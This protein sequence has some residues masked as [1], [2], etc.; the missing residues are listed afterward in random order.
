VTIQWLHVSA[1]NVMLLC[2]FMLIA[3]RVA[4]RE[5]VAK[6]V[7][8]AI[9]GAQPSGAELARADL[10]P[11]SGLRAAS[12]AVAIAAVAFYVCLWWFARSR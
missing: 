4:G 5:K 11:W 8:G 6:G 2:A 9:R 7:A 1:I 3:S 10:T 12:I